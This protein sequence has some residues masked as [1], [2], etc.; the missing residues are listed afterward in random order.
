MLNF[1]NLTG[2]GDV[3]RC[4]IHYHS[5]T[6]HCSQKTEWFVD[7]SM[8]LFD[9]SIQQWIITWQRSLIWPIKKHCRL[10][11]Q[12]LSWSYQKNINNTPHSTPHSTIL[13]LAYSTHLW[14]SIDSSLTL[15][16]YLPSELAL[17]VPSLGWATWH[18]CHVEHQRQA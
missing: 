17:R 16:I 1:G 8:S 9:W 10:N 6:L 14:L 3:T 4:Q 2:I 7:D 12:T 11:L 15:N 18:T 5:L 13:I